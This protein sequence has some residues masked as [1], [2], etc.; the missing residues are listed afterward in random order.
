VG[1]IWF[2]TVREEHRLWV[3]ENRELRSIF[4]LKKDEIIGGWRKL[5][6][7]ELHNFYFLP[8]INRMIKSRRMKWVGHVAHVGEKRNACRVSVG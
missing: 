6:N 5:H 2:L 7:E 1:D 8:N 3:F 4:G